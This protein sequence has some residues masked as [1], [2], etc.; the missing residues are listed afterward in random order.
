M[1]DEADCVVASS[2][3]NNYNSGIKA[4][5]LSQRLLMMNQCIANER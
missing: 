3:P 1:K 5:V 4:I 2:D